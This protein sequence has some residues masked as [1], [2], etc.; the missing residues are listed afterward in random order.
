MTN[1][2][3]PGEAEER[4]LPTRPSHLVGRSDLPRVAARE[5]LVQRLR[6]HDSYDDE[7]SDFSEQD[8]ELMRLIALET[9]DADSDPWVR[10]HAISTLGTKPTPENLNALSLVARA[11][12]DAD[13]RAEALLA[14]GRSGVATTAPVLAE[15]L[16]ATDQFEADSATRAL[17]EL[18][19]RIGQSQVLS[20]LRGPSVRAVAALMEATPPARRR[21]TPGSTS[22]DRP[23]KTSR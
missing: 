5:R 23:P 22:E 2:K 4:Q 20:A 21:K 6:T 12:P 7:A 11:S 9:H 8:F 16:A 18:G 19:D 14:L 13:A 3:L 15:G 1:D 17:R 10:R